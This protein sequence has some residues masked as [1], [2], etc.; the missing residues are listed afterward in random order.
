MIV[1]TDVSNTKNDICDVNKEEE[2]LKKYEK[3]V[4]NGKAGTLQNCD[5]VDDDLLKMASGDEDEAFTDFQNT[6]RDDPDQVLRY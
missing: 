3:L 5:N 4:E 6:I 1:E 2:E